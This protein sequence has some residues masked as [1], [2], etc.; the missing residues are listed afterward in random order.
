VVYLVDRH[1]PVRKGIANSQT[2]SFE[3][4][5]RHAP[6]QIILAVTLLIGGALFGPT[7]KACAGFVPSDR[8]QRP[9][10]CLAAEGDGQPADG[11]DVG[12]SVGMSANPSADAVDRGRGDGTPLD[13]AL[14]S[15]A[16][17]LAHLAGRLRRASRNPSGPS[18]QNNAGGP[19][20]CD[21]TERTYL[22]SQ[23]QGGRRFPDAE[24]D[25][26]PLLSGRLFR[27]PR[28]WS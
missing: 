6:Y 5:V 14:A 10:C 2:T 1:Q 25:R 27:P 26:G 12:S 11:G 3:F 13:N 15:R 23:A 24:I 21:I 7:S 18:G 17:G 22:P 16:A 20:A 9:E 28:C 4:S 8:S 19:S